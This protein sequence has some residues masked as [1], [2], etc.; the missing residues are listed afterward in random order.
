MEGKT[1][2]IAQRDSGDIVV[3]QERRS[4]AKNRTTWPTCC[5]AV[6][7]TPAAEGTGA[8]PDDRHRPASL[9]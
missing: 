1:I 3:V 4:V 7:S 5:G 8:R 9:S 6:A 2:T